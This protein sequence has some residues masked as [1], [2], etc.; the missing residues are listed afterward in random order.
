MGGKFFETSCLSKC[1]ILSLL[2]VVILIFLSVDT[3]MDQIQERM[4][5]LKIIFT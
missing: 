2:V 5:S 4:S 3:C 1:I